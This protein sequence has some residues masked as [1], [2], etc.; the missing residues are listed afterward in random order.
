MSTLDKVA[1]R[2]KQLVAEI[3]GDASLQREGKTQAQ[4]AKA[5]EAEADKE[6][7]EP[8]QLNPFKRLDQLT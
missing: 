3:I 2:T 7:T 8:K 5:R 6:N 4:Q 1:G